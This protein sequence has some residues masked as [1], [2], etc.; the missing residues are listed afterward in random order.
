TGLRRVLRDLAPETRDPANAEILRALLVLGG[1]LFTLTIV[2]YLATTH[3]AGAFP[4]DK[5]TL[6]LGRDFL[7]LWMYG[8][9]PFDGGEPWRFYDV[10]TYN[11]AIAQMLGPGYPGQNWPNPPTA[12][13]VMAPFGLL[14]YFQGLLAWAVVSFLA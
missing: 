12:L 4:R 1:A 3:W 9:A 7:N 11:G 6:V 10:V 13:V 5:A 2:T 14:G 8:R